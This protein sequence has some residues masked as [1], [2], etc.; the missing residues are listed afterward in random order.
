MNNILTA[1]K[2]YKQLNIIDQLNPKEEYGFDWEELNSFLK[3]VELP[4]NLVKDEP[5]EDGFEDVIW[6]TELEGMKIQAETVY[7]IGS[8]SIL[9]LV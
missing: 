5:D 3:V 4:C 1:L 8:F 9:R 6:E 7:G 2:K